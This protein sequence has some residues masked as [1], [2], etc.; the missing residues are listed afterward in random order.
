[1]ASARLL[2][3]TERYTEGIV[4]DRDGT[5][6][7]SMTN[8]GTISRFDAAT[9]QAEVWAH[10]A[11]A[12]GH[13]IDADGTHVVMSSTG[14][15][16]RLDASGRVC[17]VVAS[18]VDG[19]W[20]TYPN[21]VWL[22]QRRGGFYITDSGYK[23][24]P[25]TMP[26]DPQGRVYRVESDGTVRQVAG[27]IAYSNGVALSRDGVMLYV[28][29]STAR[30]LWAYRVRDNG[31]LGERTLV[32]EV[33]ANN[34]NT[35]PDGLTVGPADRLY[36]ANHGDREVLVYAPDGTLEQR[37]DAGNK[38]ASHVAF[39]PDART[40]YVSGGIDDEQGAGGIFAVAVGAEP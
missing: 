37:L 36:L 11:D 21:D 32:A 24:T 25:K 7:F 22:D 31:D 6:F 20:L 4:V 2:L 27:G 30:R 12:N 8:L 23:S 18:R 9:D 29:E 39:S 15:I 40:M 13:K 14:A 33:P 35:V 38:A 1:M 19:R 34:D 17:D 3:R 26:A 10:V 16:L 28:S 5:I